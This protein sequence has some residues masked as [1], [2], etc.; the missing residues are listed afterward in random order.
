[1]RSKHLLA[2]EKELKNIEKVRLRDIHHF[3]YETIYWF[4]RMGLETQGKT[5]D[6]VL[7][8]EWLK[9]FASKKNGY[10][11]SFGKKLNQLLK[12]MEG[13]KAL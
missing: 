10:C 9:K 13:G 2:K 3:Y 7:F 12:A 5:F 11:R 4:Y 1:M 8:T 6:D